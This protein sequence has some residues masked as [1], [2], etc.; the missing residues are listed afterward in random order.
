MKNT[1]TVVFGIN[2]K[3]AFDA[4][5]GDR[6]SHLF[7]QSSGLDLSTTTETHLV[8]GMSH[9]D[10]MSRLDAIR[11]LMQC[12]HLGYELKDALEHLFSVEDDEMAAVLK[13]WTTAA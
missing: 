6:M 10:D 11:E 4:D 12:D 5:I 13:E 8:T 7:Q 1:L 2:D 3:A 9:S